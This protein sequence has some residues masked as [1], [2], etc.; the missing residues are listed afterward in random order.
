MKR[1]RKCPECDGTDIYMAVVSAGG[2]H[3]PDLLPGAH[4]WWKRGKLE[5]FVCGK[6]GR[7]H[8]YVPESALPLVRESKKFRRAR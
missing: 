7:F 5:V 1:T 4:P 6:C 2:G 8:L 3:A